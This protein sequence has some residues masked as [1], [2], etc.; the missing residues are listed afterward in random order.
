MEQKV[1]Q[2]PYGV[3]DFVE[4]RKKNLYYV[5]KTEYIQKLENAGYYLMFLRPRRFGKSLFL[6]ML[7]AYYDVRTRDRFD[8]IFS[9]LYI[10]DNPTDKR[11]KFLKFNCNIDNDHAN[12]NG[13]CA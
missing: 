1:R 2:I 7:S 12:V 4:I 3:T 6:S 8:E 11:N 10:H 9:G 5:D 13:G